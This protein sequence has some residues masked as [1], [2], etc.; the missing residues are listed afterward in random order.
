[1][2][3]YTVLFIWLFLFGCRYIML[4]LFEESMLFKK[5]DGNKKQKHISWIEHA[6][7]ESIETLYW[8]NTNN[9]NW[10][11]FFLARIQCVCA[12]ISLLMDIWLGFFSHS[13]VFHHPSYLNCTV[14]AF[15]QI[16]TNPMRTSIHL[17]KPQR[18][19]IKDKSKVIH[20]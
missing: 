17:T 9:F 8:P 14:N 6:R 19:T 1:M 12:P 11:S 5:R 3:F 16:I 10:C 4:G 18:P 20:Q 13:L 15:G 7:S 2:A